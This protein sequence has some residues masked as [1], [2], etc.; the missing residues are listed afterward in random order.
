[1]RANCERGVESQNRI[2]DGEMAVR[3]ANVPIPEP[4]VAALIGAAVVHVV[5]PIRIPLS[6]SAARVIGWPM[7]AGGIGLAA[8]AVTS[9]GDADVERDSELVTTGA[10]AVSRNPMYVGWAA[11]VAGLATLRRD[12][13]MAAGW[14]F[15]TRAVTAEVLREE[16]RLSKRFGAEYSTYRRRVPRYV[17]IRR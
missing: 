1:M 3:W 14:L 4:Y 16:L 10:Y 6:P 15:A 11:A 7:L 9:A 12:P 5:A 13:W 8:W 2:I 17:R